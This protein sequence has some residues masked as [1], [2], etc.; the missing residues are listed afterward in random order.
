MPTLTVKL[1]GDPA[2]TLSKMELALFEPHRE[3][4]YRLELPG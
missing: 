4:F 1:P 3:A 2:T